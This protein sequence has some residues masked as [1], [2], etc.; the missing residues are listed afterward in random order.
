[1]LSDRNGESGHLALQVPDALVE[2]IARRVVE[3]LSDAQPAEPSPYLTVDEAAEFLRCSGKQRIYD[4]VNDGQLTPA[5]D[6]RRLLF[7]RTA[8]TDYVEGRSA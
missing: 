6:G 5:R 3:L 1:M 2:A 8:L 7:A 4:L